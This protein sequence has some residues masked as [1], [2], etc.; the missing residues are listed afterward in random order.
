MV[1][2]KLGAMETRF[3]QLIWDNEPITSGDLVKLCQ[4]ALDW[5]KSTTY[6]MLRRLCQRNIFE[7]NGGVITAKLS[8]QQI[9]ALQ[10]Q[11]FVE[12]TFDGSLPRFLAAF[13]L[14]KR[15]TDDEIEQLQKLI[16]QDRG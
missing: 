12:E 1:N 6:T 2:Y 8:A 13:T 7:H 10:S 16:H 9:L 11:Q 5:K 4:Q 15:L 14:Q 3:A